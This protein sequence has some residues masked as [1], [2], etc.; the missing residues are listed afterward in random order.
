MPQ[1]SELAASLGLDGEKIKKRVGK[2]MGRFAFELLLEDKHKGVI[3]EIRK[4]LEPYSTAEIDQLIKDKTFPFVPPDIFQMI[5]EEV[6]GFIDYIDA[7][8]LWEYLVEARPD[9][10]EVIDSEGDTGYQWFS[11]MRNHFAECIKEPALA[12]AQPAAALRDKIVMVVC[13]SCKRSFP[14]TKAEA[15]QLTVCPGCG[16]AK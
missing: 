12:Q 9:L 15:E 2:F 13:D 14:M 10:A 1:F 11:R 4:W 3:G 7:S 5:G 8:R 16:A 6:S